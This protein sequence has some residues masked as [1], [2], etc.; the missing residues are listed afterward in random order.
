MAAQH[1]LDLGNA[2]AA[3]ATYAQGCVGMIDTGEAIDV[4]IGGVTGGQQTGEHRAQ[5]DVSANGGGV[6]LLGVEHAFDG[7][8]AEAGADVLYAPHLKDLATMKLVAS[9]VS[10]PLNVVMSAADPDLTVDQIE[11]VGVKRISVGGA[12]SRLALAAFMK[13]ARDMKG[14]SF[15]WMRETMPSKDLKPVFRE[16]T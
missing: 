5:G 12:L 4:G 2:E 8:I 3:T 15:R 10:K 9:S 7:E 6:V 1:G 14:G 11:S 16:R 13:G